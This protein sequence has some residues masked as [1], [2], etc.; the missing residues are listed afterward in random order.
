MEAEQTAKLILSSNGN[1]S[2]KIQKDIRLREWCLGNMEAEQNSIFS[3][4]VSDWLGG[5]SFAQ[6]NV[7][8]FEFSEKR[9]HSRIKSILLSVL[10]SLYRLYI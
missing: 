4:R 7:Y 10:L 8:L 1:V 3:Q 9:F 2:L 6:L 5:T